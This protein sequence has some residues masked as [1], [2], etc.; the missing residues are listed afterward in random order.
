MKLPPT[1]GLLA[2]L[3]Y[4]FLKAVFGGEKE[5]TNTLT[6]YKDLDEVPE[7]ENLIVEKNKD[8]DV[9]ENML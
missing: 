8:S 1:T 3:C 4:T 9:G 7:Q 6:Q 2:A 5:D